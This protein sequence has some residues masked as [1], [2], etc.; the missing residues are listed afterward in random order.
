MAASA[1]RALGSTRLP[2]HSHPV[3]QALLLQLLQK[4]VTKE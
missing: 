2:F 4:G 1:V 3:R